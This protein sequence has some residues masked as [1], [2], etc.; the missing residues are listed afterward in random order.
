M[1]VYK[2]PHW[3][4][5]VV[6]P[7]KKRYYFDGAKDL[8]K[9]RFAP[10]RYVRGRKSVRGASIFVTDYYTVK[11]IDGRRAWYVIGSD[12]LGPMGRELIPFEKKADALVF[13]KDHQGKKVLKF[14]QVTPAIV[15]GL[16]R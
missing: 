5:V 7:D 11:L 8:F 16:D 9:Y 2:Y 12:V 4:G 1:F 14:D 3:V 15:K 13:M 10:G 6:H